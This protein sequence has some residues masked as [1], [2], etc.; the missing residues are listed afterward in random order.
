MACQAW[1]GPRRWSPTAKM[2]LGAAEGGEPTAEPHWRGSSCWTS[3][4]GCIACDA[5][6][7]W[8][9]SGVEGVLWG[10]AICS[11]QRRDHRPC[12]KVPHLAPAEPR[13]VCLLPHKEISSSASCLLFFPL[14]LMRPA[15]VRL[16]QLF[17]DTTQP[18]N[19]GNPDQRAAVTGSPV[20]AGQVPNLLFI[21][22]SS[23]E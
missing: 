10:S 12:R 6:P 13:C 11:S 21:R 9:S 20:Q 17:C 2:P 18:S 1:R 19:A 4:W 5:P 14:R 7:P 23:A 22:E 8:S 3:I 16:L 15:R